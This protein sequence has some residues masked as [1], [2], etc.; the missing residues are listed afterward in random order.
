MR[1]AVNCYFRNLDNYF[2]SQYKGSMDIAA[3]VSQQAAR[4]DSKERDG[5]R[6][7]AEKTGVSLATLYRLRSGK[8]VNPKLNI[9]HSLGLRLVKAKRPDTETK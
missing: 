2:L 8:E 3:H 7:L 6:A 1:T 5:M 9:L 4:L